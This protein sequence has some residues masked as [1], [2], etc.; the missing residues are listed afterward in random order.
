M[1]NTLFIVKVKSTSLHLLSVYLVKWDIL[2]SIE[3]FF[4]ITDNPFSKEFPLSSKYFS[5]SPAIVSAGI[6][7]HA[8]KRWFLYDLINQLTCCTFHANEV[9]DCAY[10]LRQIFLH[11]FI[12]QEQNLFFVLMLPPLEDMV[13]P[14]TI[15]LTLSRKDARQEIFPSTL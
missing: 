1:H 3:I 11:V 2:L 5:Y 13:K 9:R 14:T 15:N 4:P 6:L 12:F 10:T 7:P 8:W